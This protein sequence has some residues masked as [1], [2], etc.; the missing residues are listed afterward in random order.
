[1][2]AIKPLKNRIGQVYEPF[3]TRFIEREISQLGE[4]EVLVRIRASA[5]CI[6]PGENIRPH[7]SPV[8]S[9]MSSPAM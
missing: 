5:I 3:K 7:R 8:R 9:G 6:L 2:K 1:M 4:D